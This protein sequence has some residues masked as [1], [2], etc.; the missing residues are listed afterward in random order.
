MIQQS[1]QR[2]TVTKVTAKRVAS[3]NF[4]IDQKVHHSN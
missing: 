3:R 1:K 4:D 2:G